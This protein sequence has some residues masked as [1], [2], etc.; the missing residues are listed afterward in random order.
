MTFPFVRKK[1]AALER[2]RD[3]EEEEKEAKEEEEEEEKS[4][5]DSP[6]GAIAKLAFASSKGKE[7]NIVRY[8]GYSHILFLSVFF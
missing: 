1:E 4:P 5:G 2:V 6:P 7:C 8:G 3:V